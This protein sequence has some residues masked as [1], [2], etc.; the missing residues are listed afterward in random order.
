RNI[1]ANDYISEVSITRLNSENQSTQQDIVVRTRDAWTTKPTLSFS[2]SGGVNT[3]SIG[4]R[5]D[6][7]FGEGIRLSVKRKIDIDRNTSEFK[8][9]DDTAFGTRRSLYLEYANNSDGNVKAVHWH[10]P[11]R[12]LDDTSTFGVFYRYE[13]LINDYYVLGEESL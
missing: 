4:L 5:E 7:L 10:K 9:Q 13:K 3:S 6:N 2:R 8:F 1:R 11:Y 12:S